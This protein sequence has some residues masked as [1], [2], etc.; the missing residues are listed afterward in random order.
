[1]KNTNFAKRNLLMKKMNVNLYVLGLSMLNW[2]RGH[3]DIRH[4]VTVDKH[5]GVK[6]AMELLKELTEPAALC[7]NMSYNT[8]LC[9]CTGVRNRSLTLGR[10]RDQ[11]ISVVDAIS[12]SRALRIRTASP[13]RIRISCQSS[14]GRGSEMKTK[15]E[16]SMN[17]PENTLHEGKVRCKRGVHMKIDLLHDIGDIRMRQREILKR[18]SETP[19]FR[20][21]W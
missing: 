4:I 13:I 5:G 16:R 2:I 17:V 3:V 19:V 9:F 7:N 6:R 1:M 12:R 18:T 10:P 8:V 14:R 20:T 15:I 21:I 11:T